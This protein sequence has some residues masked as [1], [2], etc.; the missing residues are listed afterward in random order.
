MIDNYCCPTWAAKGSLAVEHKVAQFND[1]TNIQSNDF[2][3][4]DVAFSSFFQNI[5]PCNY[6][7]FS[8]YPSIFNNHQL[9]TAT[10]KR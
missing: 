6:M 7:N 9:I 1:L 5:E 2:D 3:I 8:F 10:Y 4:S